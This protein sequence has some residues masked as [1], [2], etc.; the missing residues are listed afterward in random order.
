ML[1]GL[2]VLLACQFAGELI[3][4]YTGIILPG[5]IIG[6]LLL[7]AG[8]CLWR[9]VPKFLNQSSQTLIQHLGLMFLPPS[10]GIF[11]LGER[12]DNQW[13]AIIAAVVG[14]TLLSLIFSGLLMNSLLKKKA[15]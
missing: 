8:L 12:F 1:Q 5:P 11:F 3:K 7:F 9:G 15:P 6:M 4:A 10:V 2:C 13:P 14:G